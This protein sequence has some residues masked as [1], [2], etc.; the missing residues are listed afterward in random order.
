M[1]SGL[2]ELHLNVKTMMVKNSEKTN[3]L[4]GNNDA[5]SECDVLIVSASP[6]SCSG[7]SMYQDR[8]RQEDGLVKQGMVFYDHRS[9]LFFL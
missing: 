2:I 7:L 4:L 6:M 3:V 8:N 5:A 1:H 9:F